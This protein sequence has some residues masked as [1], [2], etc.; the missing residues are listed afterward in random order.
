MASEQAPRDLTHGVPVQE[1]AHERIVAGRVGDSD[2]LLVQLGSEVLAIGARCSH[3]QGPLAE[4]LIVGETIRCPWHHA[5]FNLRTGEAERAPALDPV[6]SWPVECRDGLAR[7]VGTERNPPRGRR[8][9]DGH[10]GPESVV[11]VGGGGAGLAAAETLRAE[12]YDR[13]ITILSASSSPPCDRPTLSK[14]YLAGTGNRETIPLRDP[15]WYAVRDIELVLNARVSWIDVAGR[16]VRVAGGDRRRFGA[17]LLA[18]GASPVRLRAPGADDGHVHYLR[19]VSDSAGISAAASSARRVVV[20][21]ASFIGLEVAASLRTRG[22][23]VDV[24]SR[25]ARP[26]ERVLGPRVGRF[27]QGLHESHGVGFHLGR[28]VA[29]L[30]ARRVALDDGSV[31]DADLIVAGI[32]VEPRL[33]LARQAHLAVDHG[34][35]VN[36]YL[37]TTAGGVFA[38]G[39]IARWPDPHSGRRIRV[40]HWVVAERQ[41]ATAARNMLGARERFEAVPFFWSQHYDVAVNY[42]GHAESWDT[43]QIDGDLDGRDCTVTYRQN[44]RR[45]AVATIGRDRESLA[46]E[47]EMERLT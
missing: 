45:V 32:G 14:D 25:E 33:E 46:A 7:V 42:L 10:R 37:E 38:A 1:L 28:T 27:L 16:A 34:L 17:L 9:L 18:T 44:A 8:R 3:Y 30:D 13:P 43:A 5:C 11:I 24:V 23:A 31:I 12:G 39:D 40:E 26:M 20:I 21:G 22:L 35:I 29:S 15:S 41:G 36:E 19:S 47:V 6:P 2:A 4:G